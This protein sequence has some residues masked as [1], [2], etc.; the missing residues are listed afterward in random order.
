MSV[1]TKNLDELRK[2]LAKIDKVFNVRK[3][4]EQDI[5]FQDTAEYYRKSEAGYRFFHSAN[6]SI[7]MAL[8]HDGKFS[9]EGYYGQAKII[10]EYINRTGAK[11]VLELASGRGFNSA[12]LA[13]NN[14]QIQFVGIDLTP[15]HVAFAREHANGLANLEFHHGNFQDLPFQDGIFD[16]VFEV[17]S[18][19]HALDME[20]A[21]L[22]T[23]RVLRKGGYFISIDGFRSQDFEAF[24]E[25]LKIASKLAEV[26]MS[27]GKAWNIDDWVSLIDQVGFYVEKVDDLSAAIM[28]NLLRFQFLARGFFKFPSLSKFLVTILPYYLVQNA[29]AGIL[30]PFTVGAGLQRYYKVALVRQ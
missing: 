5:D 21:L 22:Q 9:R 29:I 15:E 26:S 19:C 14:P 28:P 24:P 8:N 17:E 16:L 30:M 18:I 2:Y 20:Q 4:I 12:F 1:D 11:K 25:D 13:K 10:Q 6:G 27:V 23:R 7:H 3:F